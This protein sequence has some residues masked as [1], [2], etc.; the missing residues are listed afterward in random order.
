[1]RGDAYS[2]SRFTRPTSTQ[3]SLG[4][5][6]SPRITTPL[7]LIPAHVDCVTHDIM[8]IYQESTIASAISHTLSNGREPRNVQIVVWSFFT[9]AHY[10]VNVWNTV[11]PESFSVVG[12]RKTKNHIPKLSFF[13]ERPLLLEA[14]SLASPSWANYASL[15]VYICSRTRTYRLLATIQRM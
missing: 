5:R 8:H 4:S 7:P 13:C 11:F 15:C 2:Q 1:M 3:I 14:V 6:H 9:L 10:D 12:L